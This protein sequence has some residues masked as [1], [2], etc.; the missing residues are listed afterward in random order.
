MQQIFQPANHSLTNRRSSMEEL[1]RH[2]VI[3]YPGI[4]LLG[5]T[6]ESKKMSMTIRVESLF[7]LCCCVFA[8]NVNGIP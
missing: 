8:D 1:N 6:S 2:S 7:K 3:L 5:Q 4:P